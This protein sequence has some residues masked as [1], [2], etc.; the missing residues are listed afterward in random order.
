MLEAYSPATDSWTR[1]APMPTA[2]GGLAAAVLEGRLYVFGGEHPQVFDEVEAYDPATGAW[3]SMKP[4]PTPRHGLTAAAGTQIHL[5]GGGVVR[6][7][8]KSGAHEVFTPPAD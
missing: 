7:A 3:R 2:R 1:L 6:G 8:S 5:V 4:M